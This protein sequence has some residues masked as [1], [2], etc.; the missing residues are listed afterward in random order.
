MSIIL[1]FALRH[2]PLVL[3]FFLA[4]TSRFPPP[5]PTRLLTNDI[6]GFWLFGVRLTFLTSYSACQDTGHA[7]LLFQISAGRLGMESDER[8]NK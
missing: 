4:S 8:G 7:R 2:S 3:D 5:S 6:P 1:C